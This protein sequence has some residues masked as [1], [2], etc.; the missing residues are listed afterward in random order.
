VVE[1]G[2]DFNAVLERRVSVTPL[3]LDLTAHA[4]LDRLRAWP[5]ELGLV[6]QMRPAAAIADTAAE[7]ILDEQIGDEPTLERR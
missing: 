5:W 3:H 2:S 6:D 4:Q 7:A 1:P